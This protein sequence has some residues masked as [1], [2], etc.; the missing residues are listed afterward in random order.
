MASSPVV[1]WNTSSDDI[2][3]APLVSGPSH[4][5]PPASGQAISSTKG[6]SLPES[7]NITWTITRVTDDMRAQ[8]LGQRGVVIWMTGLSGSGKSTMAV[9]LDA[10][11]HEAGKPSFIL[12]GDNLR[13]GLCSDLGF[14]SADRHE[15]IRR[16]GEVAKL[17][18][19]SGIIV[20]CSLISPFEADRQ[21][22]RESCLRDGVPFAEVFISASLS[23]CEQRDPKGLYRKA[24][25]GEIRGFTGIDSPYEPPR[26]PEVMLQ[27]GELTPEQ[28]LQQ[29][30]QHVVAMSALSA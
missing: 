25:S 4:S 29:L 16:T 14:S 15:N 26:H 8:R 24:R 11:L 30:V 23:V 18:A 13:H 5:E 2:S 19:Q 7:S 28:C 21:K 27:T 1:F 6:G 12:D 3:S 20:I 22:V 10:R 17:M 9:G